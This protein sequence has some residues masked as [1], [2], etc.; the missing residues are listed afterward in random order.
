MLFWN[1]EEINSQS[2]DN[3]LPDEKLC[4]E[5]F[6]KN[7]TRLEDGRFCVRKPLKQNPS[8]LGDSFHKTTKC[9]YSL[10]RRL[11]A[12]PDFSKLYHEFV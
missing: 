4:E 12:K 2:S 9:L 5:H 1:L 8:V 11:K 3:Y 6:N 10:E 7:T